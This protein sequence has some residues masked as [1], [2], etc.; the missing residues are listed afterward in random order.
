MPYLLYEN[1]VSGNCY[2]V[3]LLFH[4][5]G[6]EYESRELSVTDRS[7]RADVL[8][9]LSPSLNVPTVVLL[10]GRPWPSPT[11]SSG[12][13]PTGPSRGEFHSASSKHHVANQVRLVKASRP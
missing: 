2:K 4:L 10:D 8:G 5:L 6:V 13:S 1:P 11:G 9:G 7:G 12:T 3:R